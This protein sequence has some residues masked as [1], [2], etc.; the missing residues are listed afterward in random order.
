LVRLL[1]IRL[2]T[3]HDSQHHYS[4]ENHNCIHEANYGNEIPSKSE[5]VVKDDVFICSVKG[6]GQIKTIHI[7]CDKCQRSFCLKHREHDCTI[8]MSPVTSKGTSS[9]HVRGN[10][11]ASPA[12][13]VKRGAHSSSLAA[14]VALMKLKQLAKGNESI[15]QNERMY[16]NV[17]LPQENDSNPHPTFV[18][19]VWTIGKVIDVLASQYK[20]KNT[21][22]V[23]HSKKLRILIN[24][25][26]SLSTCDKVEDLIDKIPSGSTL[27]LHYL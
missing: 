4:S 11:S 17:I 24:D 16:Y 20:L 14:K 5:N 18:S 25:E 8:E 3:V 21:N 12:K 22:D 19:K 15:P 6:C 9:S 26:E 13:P 7:L 1:Y 23:V 2:Y 10:Q 27:K